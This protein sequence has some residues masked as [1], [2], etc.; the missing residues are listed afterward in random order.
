VTLVEPKKVLID[1]MYRMNIDKNN[2]TRPGPD[3]DTL[4]HV[5]HKQAGSFAYHLVPFTNEKHLFKFKTDAKGEAWLIVGAESAFEVPAE[6][7]VAGIKAVFTG[8][9]GV[10]PAA[11]RGPRAKGNASVTADGRRADL[12]RRMQ[13]PVFSVSGSADRP[14]PSR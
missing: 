3:M 11:L 8:S 13:G 7:L 12:S 4:G 1:A 9:S 2:Q 10:A 14:Y 5:N 6:L